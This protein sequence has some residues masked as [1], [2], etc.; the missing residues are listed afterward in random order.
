M[1][2]AELKLYH[3]D[4]RGVDR[5]GCHRGYPRGCLARWYLNHPTGDQLHGACGYSQAPEQCSPEQSGVDGF[6][7]E[8]GNSRC[9]GPLTGDS[10]VEV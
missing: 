3:R 7:Q 6:Y 10:M 9:Y 1:A 8:H 2:S 5:C 4:V